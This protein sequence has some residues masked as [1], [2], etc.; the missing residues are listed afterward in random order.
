[1]MQGDTL[2]GVG[3]G[4]SS[5]SDVTLMKVGSSF[6]RKIALSYIYKDSDSS[7]YLHEGKVST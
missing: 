6:L 4:V 5:F 2:R 3:E 7:C 1:M